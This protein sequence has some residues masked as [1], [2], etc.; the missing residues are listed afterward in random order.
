MMRAGPGSASML[1]VVGLGKR[2]GD[3]WACRNIDLTVRSGEVLAIAGENGAGK[4][5]TMNCLHGLYAPTIGRIEIAGDPVTFRS[6]ADAE[7]AGISMIPQ[8]LELFPEL[9][10]VENLFVGRARPRN[11]CGAFD[12]RAMQQRAR[13]I[14]TDLGVDVDVNLPVRCVSAAT[15]KL[16]E[17]ARALNRD[18]RLIIMDEPTAALTERDTERLLSVIGRLNK[19][20]VAVIYITHRLEEI[21]RIADRV[22]VLRDGSMVA[23]GHRRDFDMASLIHAMVGRPVDHLFVRAAS[24]PGEVVLQARKLTR[25]GAIADIDFELRAGEVLG[26]AGLIGAGRSELAQSIVGI[27]PADSGSILL[28]GQAVRIA[29]IDHAMSLGIAYLPEE[30][31]SQ[32]LILPFSITRNITFAALGRFTRFGLIE[33]TRE[34]AFARESAQRVGVCGADLDSPVEVLSGGNQQ[35]VL[36]AKILALDPRI[37]IF[38]EP[39]RGVDVGAKADIYALIDALANQGKAIL[40]ISSEMNELL[41]MADRILVMHEGRVTATFSRADFS[42]QLIA[43]AA[44]GQV[45]RH[46]A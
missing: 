1:N 2:F 40:L 6:P 17:I 25:R 46:V 26:V 24:V 18:A 11:L 23:S 38:D 44:A 9:T 14:L 39:T 10:I 3:T 42:A 29:S 19:R 16:V 12:R 43:S 13:E 21:F 8:E 32:G 30:R 7:A 41:C 15:A 22:C 35:K 27:T 34:R 28:D 4:S 33:R 20:G 31:R 36:I 5:T 45:A 37:V